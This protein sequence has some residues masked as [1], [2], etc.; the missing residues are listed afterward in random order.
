[1]P[2]AVVKTT[3][4]PPVH[5]PRTLDVNIC[6][7]ISIWYRSCFDTWTIPKTL[8]LSVQKGRKRQSNRF[9]FDSTVR[10]NEE[11]HIFSTLIPWKEV[12]KRHPSHNILPTGSP[13]RKL[14]VI[15]TSVLIHDPECIYK[16]EGNDVAIPIFVIVELDDLKERKKGHVA[17][18]SRVASRTIQSIKETMAITKVSILKNKTSPRSLNHGGESKRCRKTTTQEKWIMDHAVGTRHEVAIWQSCSW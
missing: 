11:Y 8:L 2:N 15:D 9:E 6:D 12:N 1:M 16:F 13:M 5:S 10:K 3:T 14:Y 17:F 4:Y 18:A 7:L